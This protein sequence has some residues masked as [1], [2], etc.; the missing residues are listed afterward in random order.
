MCSSSKVIEGPDERE[1]IGDVDGISEGS[2]ELEGAEDVEGTSVTSM[3]E[4]GVET[5]GER[6]G[7]SVL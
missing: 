5:D 4:G 3:V 2:E 7:S 1:G 6:E